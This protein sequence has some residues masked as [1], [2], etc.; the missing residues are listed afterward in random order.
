MVVGDIKRAGVALRSIVQASERCVGVVF[1]THNS[2]RAHSVGDHVVL[3]NRGRV[4]DDRTAHG[5]IPERLVPE[6]AGGAELEA[7]THARGVV[8]S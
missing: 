7:S 2:N 3:L 5:V 1:I 6:M 4:I 8:E